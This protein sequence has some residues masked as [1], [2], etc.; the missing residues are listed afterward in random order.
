[1]KKL[2][3]LMLCVMAH[4]SSDLMAQKKPAAKPPKTQSVPS[5]VSK[6][7]AANVSKPNVVKLEPATESPSAAAAKSGA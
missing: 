5:A 3:I 4:I 7:P 2:T 1:M 6:P